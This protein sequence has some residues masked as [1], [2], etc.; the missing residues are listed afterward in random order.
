MAI[1]TTACLRAPPARAVV[2]RRQQRRRGRFLVSL[3]VLAGRQRRQPVS[4][5]YR[6]SLG[7]AETLRC[8]GSPHQC[9]SDSSVNRWDEPFC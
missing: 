3:E 9:G 2:H 1:T 7:K 4:R 6:A 5:A 8:T